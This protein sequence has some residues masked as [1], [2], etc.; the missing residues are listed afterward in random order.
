M[1]VTQVSNSSHGHDLYN[2]MEETI[3]VREQ[4]LLILYSRYLSSIIIQVVTHKSLMMIQML[5][6]HANR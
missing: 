5:K 3:F 6:R 1:R 4:N 2:R